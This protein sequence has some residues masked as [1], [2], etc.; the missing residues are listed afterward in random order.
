ME[1]RVVGT[2][3]DWFNLVPRKFLAG[4]PILPEHERS[5]AKVCV[6]TEH[7]ARRLLAGEHSL[8]QPIKLG[9]D[10][11]TVIGIVESDEG[12]STAIQTPDLPNDA[13]IPLNVH[14]E[15][16]GEITRDIGTRSIGGE[17][18]ELHGL[19]IQVNNEKN[20]EAV[21]NSIRSMLMKF[22]PKVDY[23]LDVPL[24]LLRQTE[25]TKRRWTWTLFA[26]ALISLLVG[27]I[28]IMNIMLATVT[29]RTREIGIRRA[30]G[31][32]RRQIIGQFLIETI[33]LTLGGGLLGVIAGPAFAW[34]ITR[35]A[36]MPTVV[37]LYSILLSLGISVFIGVAFGIYP[38]YRAATVDP[39]IALR[40]E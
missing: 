38:A 13:Y 24:T 23:R 39:I 4:G 26:I 35:I 40:H 2:T 33:V 7:A 31:A 25:E 27:G 11:F 15:R 10:F 9:T 37:P 14:R 30:I 6:L 3:P 12:G 29:E 22:H 32:K 1:M 34:A 16:F 20:V 19:I 21:A 18:V 28:G 17:K 5:S 8:G 36:Q